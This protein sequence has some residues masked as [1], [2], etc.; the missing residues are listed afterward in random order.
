VTIEIVRTRQWNVEFSPIVFNISYIVKCRTQ[1]N[2]VQ[3]LVVNV[4]NLIKTVRVGRYAALFFAEGRTILQ[5]V[6]T[7]YPRRIII[8]IIPNNIL[9]HAIMMRLYCTRE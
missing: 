2:S 4:K 1:Y 3:P 7:V 9:Y 6:D 5:D 8:M